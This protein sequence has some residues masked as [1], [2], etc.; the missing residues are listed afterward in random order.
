VGAK[1]AIADYNASAG[2]YD[3][4]YAAEQDT[5]IGFLTSRLKPGQGA[6]VL[7]VGCGTGR[8]FERLREGLF[9][10]G[11]DP[12]IG[13]LREAKRKGIDAE[14]ILADA[15]HIPIRAG[16]ADYVFS[17]SVIQLLEEPADGASEIIRV[18]KDGGL[19]GVSALM[20]SFSGERL[21][22]LFGVPD[23]EAYDS[24]TMKDAFII[25]Q[26]R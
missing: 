4:R 26:K 13:M 6:T 24:D 8:L 14:V 22:A 1:R 11:I 7:D 17:I 3:E 25:A 15:G 19:L 12:S 20:K 16:I 5:K 2:I 10:V 18:L 9:C 23:G 21:M